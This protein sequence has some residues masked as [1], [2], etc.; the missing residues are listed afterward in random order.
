MTP[1]DKPMPFAE[2]VERAREICKVT[3]K[4]Y[5]GVSIDHAV[6][7]KTKGWLLEFRLDE[8]HGSCL[9]AVDSTFKDELVDPIM[10]AKGFERD[11]E[12]ESELKRIGGLDAGTRY[13]KPIV[14]ADISNPEQRSKEE[15]LLRKPGKTPGFDKKILVSAK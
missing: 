9:V 15:N 3:R 13:Y 8:K 7:L 12:K 10:K 11:S 5:E 6:A 4:H 14:G 2:R 1:W